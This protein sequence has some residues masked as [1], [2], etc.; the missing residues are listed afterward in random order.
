M[1]PWIV[2]SQAPLSMG[3]PVQEYWSGYPFLSPEDIPNPGIEPGSLALQVDSFH[4]R[5]PALPWL[6]EPSD[7]IPRMPV[8]AGVIFMMDK[9]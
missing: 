4:Q 9:F 5:R 1:I 2:A 7:V 6:S 8:I 3:F